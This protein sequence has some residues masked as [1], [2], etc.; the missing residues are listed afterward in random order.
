MYMSLPVLTLTYTY[1]TL[2]YLLIHTLG[3]LICT[4]STDLH[5]VPIR[6]SHFISSHIK[7]KSYTLVLL[8]Y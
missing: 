1:L 4:L 7:S 6:D 2:P 5:K 3:Y 8:T